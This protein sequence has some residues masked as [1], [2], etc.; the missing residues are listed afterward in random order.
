MEKGTIWVGASG[1]VYPH[2]VGPFYPA[3][4]S[5]SDYL[6]FYTRHFPTVEINRS[7]YRLPERR[8]CEAWARLAPPGF[9]FAVKASRYLTHMKK[10]KDPQESLQRLVTAAEGLGEHLGPFLF[11][12]PPHWRANLDRLADL[13]ALLRYP[14]AFEFR[15]A[16]WFAPE[17]LSRLL[18]V[19]EQAPVPCTVVIAVGGSLPTPP[20]LPLSG[21]FGYYRFH[22]GSEGIGF[23]DEEL[24]TWAERLRKDRRREA[25]VYFNNDPKGYAVRDATRLRELLGPLAVRPFVPASVADGRRA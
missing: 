23:S 20:D 7:F 3:K 1:W 25:Y 12:L 16:S 18:K 19:L 11:Q 13:V 22:Q 9:R 5:E 10:L 4:R 17:T 15:D 8:H 21:S 14:A 24:M 6:A 2:W